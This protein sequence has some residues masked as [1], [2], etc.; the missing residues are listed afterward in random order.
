M[1]AGV[2]RTTGR[3]LTG[4]GRGRPNPSAGSG[5]ALPL[6]QER[7]KNGGLRLSWSLV[8]WLHA[9]FWG[10]AEV[11]GGEDE[12]RSCGWVGGV[13]AGAVGWVDPMEPEPH[14]VVVID[15]AVLE[16]RIRKPGPTHAVDLVGRRIANR[17]AMRAIRD[18]GAV[19]TGWPGSSGRPPPGY[20][21]PLGGGDE[22]RSGR[23]RGRLRMARGGGGADLG[24]LTAGAWT[25]R[26]GNSWKSERGGGFP[27]PLAR[28][29]RSDRAS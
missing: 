5:Q 24:Q 17:L 21:K 1:G 6:P 13:Y 11:S 12:R 19:R 23:R 26:R 15:V 7:G 25:A 28:L 22:R 29:S 3:P 18:N 4:F 14:E 16:V 9:C 8:G 27:P 10:Y 2:G 20:A